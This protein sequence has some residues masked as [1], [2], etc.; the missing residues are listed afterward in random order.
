[1][2]YK[3]A[4]AYLGI[5]LDLLG[6]C[7]KTPPFSQE[8]RT[9]LGKLNLWTIGVNGILSDL[10]PDHGRISGKSMNSHRAARLTVQRATNL[11]N[12]YREVM[13]LT[14][15][16]MVAAGLARSGEVWRAWIMQIV[17]TDG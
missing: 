3:K 2:D 1:M 14:P 15:R 17:G 4:K 6:E 13:S 5:Y 9:V 8:R 16:K 10:S 12:H 11:I 7:E